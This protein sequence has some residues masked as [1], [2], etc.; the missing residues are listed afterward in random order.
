MNTFRVLKVPNP[1]LNINSLFWSCKKFIFCLSIDCRCFMG[2]MKNSLPEEVVESQTKPKW[3]QMDHSDCTVWF[4][5]CCRP[6]RAASF[7][8]FK[9]F[10]GEPNGKSGFHPRDQTRHFAALEDTASWEHII[11]LIIWRA[12][13]EFISSLSFVFLQIWW[14]KRVAANSFWPHK[15]VYVMLAGNLIEQWKYGTFQI[16]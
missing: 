6:P 7:V 2:L 14:R 15:K 11:T 10:S 13:I 1:Y 9:L 8:F 16:R 5:S 12:I 4:S 3:A